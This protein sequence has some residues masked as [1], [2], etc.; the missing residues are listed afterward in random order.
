MIKANYIVRGILTPDGSNI[1]V[2]KLDNGSFAVGQSAFYR[3][4]TNGNIS[5]ASRYS[6]GISNLSKYFPEKLL[7]DPE[8]SVEIEMKTV[9]LLT[10]MECLSICKGIILANLDGKINEKWSA[11]PRKAQLLL[12]LFAESGVEDAIKKALKKNPV[13]MDNSFE[14]HLIRLLISK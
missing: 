3:Y 8:F 14:N 6:L 5:S 12:F 13:I 10:S 4:L 1:T 9:R 7:K 2:F 11:A